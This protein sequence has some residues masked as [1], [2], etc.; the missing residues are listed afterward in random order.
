MSTAEIVVVVGGVAAI[1]F[2]NWYFFIA[3]STP[4]SAPAVREDSA[5]ENNANGK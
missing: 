5:R 2:V 3:R 1:A 4:V